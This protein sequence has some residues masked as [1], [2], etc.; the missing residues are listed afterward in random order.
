MLHRA[1]MLFSSL[2]KWI[3]KMLYNKQIQS[4]LGD[5]TLTT[6]LPSSLYVAFCFSH[7]TSNFLWKAK[8]KPGL[9]IWVNVEF[10]KCICSE[11]IPTLTIKSVII[12]NLI[13]Q[14]LIIEPLSLSNWPDMD[15]DM[16]MD[17]LHWRIGR[18]FST[19]LFPSSFLFFS[20]A[21]HFPPQIL[22]TWISLF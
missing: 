3:N 20:S 1:K 2:A 4:L 19:W 7:I 15:M 13:T 16:D 10:S 22:D 5:L 21:S 18:D 12:S 11:T 6:C 8:E 14:E 17:T 9:F